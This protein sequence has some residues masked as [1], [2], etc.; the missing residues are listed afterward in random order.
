MPRVTQLAPLSTLHCSLE[1]VNF[2]TKVVGEKV[3]AEKGRVRIIGAKKARHSDPWLPAC[4][5]CLKG[6]QADRTGTLSSLLSFEMTRKGAQ[7]ITQSP[8]KEIGS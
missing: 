2:S 1:F 3:C 8:E 6:H 4:P 5:S 7:K